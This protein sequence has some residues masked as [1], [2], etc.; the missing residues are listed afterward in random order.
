MD[1]RSRAIA[2]IKDR[3]QCLLLI[4]CLLFPSH[5]GCLSVLFASDETDG[6][7]TVTVSLARMKT[8]DN[9]TRDNLLSD[10]RQPA[11]CFKPVSKKPK[12]ES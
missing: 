10:T 3:G 6:V 1:D 9:K 11:L 7:D 2:S 12:E 8:R 4:I 5:T